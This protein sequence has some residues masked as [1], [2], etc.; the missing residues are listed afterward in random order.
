MSVSVILPTYN[1]RGNIVILIRN[2]IATLSK[3]KAI[4]E[5][6]VVDDNSTDG[7][8]DAIKKAF[9]RNRRV[10]VYIRKNERGLATAIWHGIQ[11]AKG[12]Y[13]VV[14][15]TDLSHEPKLLPRMLRIG[16]DKS[17]VIASRYIHGGGMEDKLRNV[18][19]HLFNIYLRKLL[20]IPVTDFLSGYFCA[21]TS[22]FLLRS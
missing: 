13:V 2:I 14:M 12:E 10:R 17:M 8:T 1:E 21:K 3:T 6:L 7:T 15:D 5:I 19:S 16:N 22:R 11:K 9:G 20:R 18:L 4:F